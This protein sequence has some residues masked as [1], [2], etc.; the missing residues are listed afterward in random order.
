MPDLVPNK[1]YIQHLP[2]NQL[3][4]TLDMTGDTEQT[5]INNAILHMPEE[6]VE[7]SPHSQLDFILHGWS[8][9]SKHHLKIEILLKIYQIK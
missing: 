6:K 4:C 5:R 1:N 9:S 3:E 8:A 2:I 7:K